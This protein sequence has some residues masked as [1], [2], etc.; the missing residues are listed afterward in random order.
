M[1]TFAFT[2]TILATKRTENFVI[3]SVFILLKLMKYGLSVLE[4]T[5][6]AENVL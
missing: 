5:Y 3:F 1:V 6:V 2:N 4:G